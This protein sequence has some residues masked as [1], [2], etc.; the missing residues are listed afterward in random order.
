MSS[1]QSEPGIENPP[2]PDEE[3]P[4]PPPPPEETE[5]QVPPEDAWKE[6]YEDFVEPEEKPKH[7]KKRRSHWG[8]IAFTV[9]VI[10]ILIAWTWAS[11]SVMDPVGD[12][13]VRGE[14]AYATWGNYTGYVKTYAGNTTWGVA[15]S[16]HSTS[17]GNRT[18]DVYVLITK[19]SENTSNWWFVGTAIKLQNVSVFLEDGTYLE[20]MTNSSD[21]G[22]G[23]TARVPVSFDSPGNYSLYVYV[24]FLVYGVMRIGFI[25][26]KVVSVQKVYL[27]FPIAVT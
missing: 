12:T 16:G 11:P 19:I 24:K 15:L 6:N 3:L 20:S 27:D 4:P 14:S 8:A 7:R 10:V 23:R 17:A 5:S 18:I 13:Y 22:F 21:L 2:A 9:I 25:P 1:E 26:A